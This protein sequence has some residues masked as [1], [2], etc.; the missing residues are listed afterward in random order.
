MCDAASVLIM[1]AGANGIAN[2]G[3]DDLRRKR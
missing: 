2:P 1:K 3:A